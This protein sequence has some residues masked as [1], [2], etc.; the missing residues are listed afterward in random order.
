MDT[1]AA[2][3]AADARLAVLLKEVDLP[4]HAYERAERRYDDLAEWIGRSESALAQYDPHVFVQGSFALGTA[5]RPINEDEEY[6]L[7]FTCKLR[8]GISR[9]THS[10]AQV[11]A[12]LGRELEAY[13]EARQIKN[14]LDEKR[15]CW[16]LSYQDEL[17]F[18]MDVVPG[19][20]ADEFRRSELRGLMERTGIERP[21]A[22]EAARRALWIT[23]I[24]DPTYH[25]LSDAWP[26][27]NPGG[28]QLWFRSRM[29]VPQKGMLAEAQIDP[30]PVYRSKSPLQQVVQLLKRHRDNN[31][32]N[33]PDAK[34]AS[35]I[36]TTVAG[37]AYQVGDSISK[38]MRRVLDEF[39]RIRVSDTNKILNPVNPAENFA[40]R[41]GWDDCAH[42]QLKK[43]FHE[44][45]WE[46]NRHFTEV[47]NGVSRHRMVEIA[48]DALA[49]KLSNNTLE[50][51]GYTA[52]AAQATGRVVKVADAPPRPWSR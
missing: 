15:R 46:A 33:L 10:Q 39:E 24:K 45:V 5:I 21:V 8:L 44:W 49:V 28:Y 13:R 52:L 36:L 7:D 38:T 43:N 40:D 25:E 1:C 51:L 48:E 47:M 16:R 11:K 6:D 32:K 27:S 19:I 42:L 9:D 23:D 12:E 14:Q 50:R 30:V 18:H 26:L 20:R 37:H 35:I 17:P 2:T 29:Q 22:I 34:P 41:W 31:F 3:T 4:E